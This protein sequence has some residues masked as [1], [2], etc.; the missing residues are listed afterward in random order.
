[1]RIL[2]LAY[3]AIPIS[4]C[5]TKNIEQI[6]PDDSGRASLPPLTTRFGVL[7]QGWNLHDQILENIEY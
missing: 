1:M 3:R 7:A 5:I 4:Q 2:E 6:T